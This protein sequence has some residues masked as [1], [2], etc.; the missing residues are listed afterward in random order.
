MYYPN[1]WTKSKLITLFK[2]GD[3]MDPSNYRGINIMSVF[4]KLYDIILT[5]R[6]Q[7]WY[8]PDEEQAGARKGRGCEEQ[9]LS[10]RLIIDIARKEK[11]TLYVIF[12]DFEKAYDKVVRSKLMEVLRNLGCGSAMLQAIKNSLQK[13]V[14]IIDK[15]Y[16]ESKVGVRQGSPSSCF[17]FTAYVNP[18]IRMVKEYGEDG[19]LGLLHILLL[20]DDTVIF[21]TT[22]EGAIWKFQQV[23]NYCD[24][25]G[26]KVNQGKTKYLS[27]NT[28]DREPLT[29]DRLSVCWCESYVYLGNVIMNSAIH[30]QVDKHL[31]SSMKNVHK[32]QSFLAKNSDAPFS[33]KAKVWSAA[34]NS[35]LLYGAETWWTSN[36][37]AADK[38]Y[39]GTLKDLLSVRTTVCTDLV[40]IESGMGSASAN[41]KQR[42][43]KFLKKLMARSD[44]NQ[45]YLS[46]LI[47]K[48]VEVQSPMGVYIQKLQRIEGDP[49][50]NELEL[51]RRKI[52]NNVDS[53][54]RSTYKLLNPDLFAPQIY[55]GQSSVP[56]HQRIAYTRI[57]LG[58]HRLKIET[59]RWSRTPRER[60]LCSCGHVQDEDH[61]LLKCS[62]ISDI[63]Q[64]FPGLDYSSLENLM[65]TDDMSD[66][67]KY[68]YR[69][70]KKMDEI[71]RII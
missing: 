71:N 27:V 24:Q 70:M 14:S 44:Y 41:I 54:R 55:I 17:L 33:V 65:R 3:P 56:E 26:M 67:S 38:L 23:L 10:L 22:R 52:R 58:S 69:V 43:V 47:T 37:K 49:V 30:E 46:H 32:F 20:M 9:I 8:T 28:N 18:M 59:G 35:A 13:T 11:K 6:L 5:T 34:L 48:A 68:V 16:I 40:Y 63:R 66:I 62:L 57:R 7:N 19:W 12:I 25:Y 21:S 29:F 36:L 61:V 2:K 53:S 64:S 51:L 60:R 15:T 39:L 42:Q 31:K 4:P 45:S 50:R 1:E